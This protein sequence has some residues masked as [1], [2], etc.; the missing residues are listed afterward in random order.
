MFKKMKIGK[1]LSSFFT[2][3]ALIASISGV[4]GAIVLYF[5]NNYYSLII[6]DYSTTL[7][8]LSLLYGDLSL[9]RVHIRDIVMN[10]DEQV[11]FLAQEKLNQIGFEV[12]NY[13]EALRPKMKTEE[14]RLLFEELDNI[15]ENY[16]MVME[17]V[18]ENA[19]LGTI[20]GNLS[21]ELI[22]R[23]EGTPLAEKRLEVTKRL[24]D[25]VIEE[26]TNIN[27]EL[28]YRSYR[29]MTFIIAIIVISF[30]VAAVISVYATRS[31]NRPLKL[32]ENAAMRIAGHD[33]DFELNLDTYDEIG[34]VA[35]VLNTSVK[36]AFVDLSEKNE[37]IMDSLSY[38]RKI[39]R[40]ILPD[41]SNFDNTFLDYNILW[42]PRDE[43]GGDFYWISGFE[44]GTLLYIGDCT[45]HGTPGAMLTMLC[46]A[47]LNAVVNGEN[48]DDLKNVIWKCDQKT[49]E[50]MRQ[51]DHDSNIEIRDSLDFGMFFID[52]SGN[53][54]FS[55]RNMRL[56]TCD[57][58]KVDVIKG[59][60]PKLRGDST[61]SNIDEIEI[62][63]ISYEKGRK[64]YIASDGLFDQIGGEKLLP[65]GYSSIKDIIL[66][67]HDKNLSITV[68]MIWQAF[69]QH[70]GGERRRDDV[71][72]I[73]FEI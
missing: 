45:G 8:N 61:F 65:F 33:T 6:D 24:I 12:S 37:M 70:M 5:T 22:M 34:T 36:K 40:N 21:A 18:I 4:T 73:A 20:E 41:K 13:M 54:K 66:D 58:T 59:V 23:R 72:L 38:A 16:S 64:F 60:R 25:L 2:V 19:L 49:G 10:D 57:G 9:A 30:G 14:C 50:M 67:N 29:S 11:S 32:V 3:V 47:V 15:N 27:H 35:K 68:D 26:V 17:Q 62:H 71:T 39:Q 69:N 42:H 63:Q 43:V 7:V 56:Y 46:I 28:D 52:K 53:I 48:C 51:G 55:A 44:K 31:I 1:R